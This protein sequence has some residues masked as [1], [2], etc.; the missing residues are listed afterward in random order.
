MSANGL[1]GQRLALVDLKQDAA[2]MGGS[3]VEERKSD[4]EGSDAMHMRMSVKTSYLTQVAR[5]GAEGLQTVLRIVAKWLGEDPQKVVVQPNLEFAD[6]TMDGDKLVKWMTARTLGAP[7]S[8][9][10]IHRKLQEND[11]T[12]LSYED[13]IAK[14][15]QEDEEDG[16]GEGG[17]GTGV[18]DGDVDNNVSGG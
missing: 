8:K 6:R 15:R 3:F 16:L 17:T 4:A 2:Q 5:S 13:E 1:E 7:L 14:K 18:E 12:E 11:M 10:S 9:E